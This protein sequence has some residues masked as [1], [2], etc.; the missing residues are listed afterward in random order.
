MSN[1]LKSCKK[2]TKKLYVHPVS[3]TI[4]ICFIIFCMS[5]CIII[6]LNCLSMVFIPKYFSVYFLRTKSSHTITGERSKLED[7]TSCDSVTLYADWTDIDGPIY[8]LRSLTSAPS[9][10]TTDCVCLSSHLCSLI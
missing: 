2:C 1:L 6:F 7:L 9:S 4:D 10:S 5:I 8:V 3:P